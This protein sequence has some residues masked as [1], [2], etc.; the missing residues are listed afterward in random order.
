[1]VLNDFSYSAFQSAHPEIDSTRLFS[2]YLLDKG[3]VEYGASLINKSIAENT[4]RVVSS[5]DNAA[6]KISTTIDKATDTITSSI[7][8]AA[9]AIC[10]RLDDIGDK[11]DFLNRRMDIVIEQNRMSNMLL[12]DIVT[13][14][15][16]PD[17]EKE[18]QHEILQG[19]KFFA[20]AANDHS[21]Y[22][23]AL[24]HLLKAESMQRQD[25][26]V[27]HR[28]G[29]I[30]LYVDQFLDPAKALDYFSR[31]AKYAKSESDPDAV[32]LVNILTNPVNSSYTTLLSQPNRIR[33]LAADSYEKA[34]FS[35]YVLNDLDQAVINQRLAYEYCGTGENQ[36]YLAKYL[37]HK[38]EVEESIKML[39]SAVEKVPSLAIAFFQ[40]IDMVE[41]SE[42]VRFVSAENAG[43][44]DKLQ[45]M[46]DR[47]PSESVRQ[48]I[49]AAFDGPYTTKRAVYKRLSRLGV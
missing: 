30:Y 41:R 33:T 22:E 14:L 2:S 40:E 19:I 16:I 3:R 35:A 1:M 12:A 45:E 10:G 39:E 48:Y 44:T 11:L 34:A 37:A 46:Y 13:L 9:E 21:L 47:A 20:N 4:N 23:D 26:F 25:Y 49:Q 31:A 32:R 24:E 7:A 27:L 28:I 38:G 36:F 5:I 42:L 43:L 17:A 8:Q 6:T 15:K 29:C 18:R